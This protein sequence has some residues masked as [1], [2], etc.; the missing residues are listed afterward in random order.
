MHAG[1]GHGSGAAAAEVQVPKFS[2]LYDA[3]SG[4]WSEALHGSDEA[5]ARYPARSASLNC[6]GA[7]LSSPSG[8][9]SSGGLNL[10]G[11]TLQLASPDGSAGQPFASLRQKSARSRASLRCRAA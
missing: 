2:N 8:F 5:D 6:N 11:P 1:H 9:P 3:A 4:A 7:A 10:L